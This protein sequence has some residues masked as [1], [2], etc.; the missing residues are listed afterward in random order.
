MGTS[1]EIVCRVCDREIE[2]CY[3]CENDECASAICARD[4][5]LL[6][7][8]SIPHPHTHGG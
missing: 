8:E 6:T 1:T 7:G 3:C 4:L 5:I 2:A